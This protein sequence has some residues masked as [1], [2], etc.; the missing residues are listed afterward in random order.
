MYTVHVY[1]VHVYVIVL[2]PSIKLYSWVLGSKYNVTPSACV[3][4]HKNH[5]LHT[6]INQLLLVILL[7]HV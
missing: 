5:V 4:Y 6:V 1:S 2:L 3:N 7:F